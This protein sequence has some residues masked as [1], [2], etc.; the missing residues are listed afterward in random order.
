MPVAMAV[1]SRIVGSGGKASIWRPADLGSVLLSLWIVFQ[2][3][4]Y[5]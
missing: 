3:E 1:E 4:V 2:V 5:Q